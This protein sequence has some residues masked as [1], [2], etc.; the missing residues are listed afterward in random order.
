MK[1]ITII[2]HCLWLVLALLFSCGKEEGTP[3]KEE[4]M[5]PGGSETLALVIREAG[6][7][8]SKVVYA[9]Q[10]LHVEA[11]ITAPKRIAHIKMQ[12]TL[13]E[14]NYGWDFIKTY[15]TGY[16][17]LENV[18]FHEHVDVPENARPGNYELLLIAVDELGERVQA[19]A[20]FEIRK[21]AD[22]PVFT[23]PRVTLFGGMLRIT[24]GISAPKKIAKVD[25]EVQ[26]SAWTN[27]YAHT[28]AGMVGQTA[29]QLNRDIDISAAPA[30][31]YH[32]NIMVTDQ[33]DKSAVYQ[34]HLD[35]V[36]F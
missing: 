15:T 28:D 17:G 12:I 9:G 34:A 36:D 30:G 10:D 21:D 27:M 2:Q 4:D 35:K 29:Y 3:P 22:L 19:K 20:D 13:A 5:P 32:V 16:T 1:K 6:I 18:D 25:I 8:N 31:H 11:G 33:G 7:G 14:T 24:A 23:S 26:S